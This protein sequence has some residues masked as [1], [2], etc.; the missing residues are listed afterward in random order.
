MPSLPSQP[1]NI[2]C[3]FY[4]FCTSSYCCQIYHNSCNDTISERECFRN[5]VTYLIYKTPNPTRQQKYKECLHEAA[6]D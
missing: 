2:K 5:I 1:R 3:M 6:R 4:K